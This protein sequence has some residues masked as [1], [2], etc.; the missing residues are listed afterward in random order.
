MNTPNPKN[1]TAPVIEPLQK[2]KSKILILTSITLGSVLVFLLLFSIFSRIDK[3]DKETNNTDQSEVDQTEEDLTNGQNVYIVGSEE[4]NEGA[5]V[6]VRYIRL[7]T[8]SNTDYKKFC[9]SEDKCP[10]GYFVDD[11]SNDTKVFRISE[12]ANISLLHKYDKSKGC[13][14]LQDSNGIF[15][16]S[17]LTLGEFLTDPCNYTSKD[18]KIPLYI[19]ATDDEIFQITEIYIP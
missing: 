4:T 7:L 1:T 2:E 12:S 6:T 5:N 3:K 14:I 8:S 11:S 15:T 16:Y 13:A 9:T 18:S 19:N 17:I 10:D